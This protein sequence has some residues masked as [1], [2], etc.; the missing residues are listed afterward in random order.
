M[1]LMV[2]SHITR[3]HWG[4]SV[5]IVKI[6]RCSFIIVMV[7]ECILSPTVDCNITQ[8]WSMDRSLS[9]L[10]DF[11]FSLL[12]I[13]LVHYGNFNP[14]S[15]SSSANHDTLDASFISLHR[16]LAII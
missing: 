13:I 11:S 3:S 7:A 10:I 6:K 2:L 5:M 15:S 12:L 16:L 9:S 4:I 1:Y 8:N 14:F